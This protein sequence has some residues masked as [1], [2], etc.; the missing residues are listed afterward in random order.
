MNI[1]KSLFGDKIGKYFIICILVRLMIVYMVYLILN[2]K[3]KYNNNFLLKI[4]IIILFVI[5]FSFL[6]QYLTKIRDVGAFNQDVW[7]DYLRPIHGY[8]YVLSSYL[9]YKNDKKAIYLLLLDTII[10]ILGFINNRLN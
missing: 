8:L 9:I 5:G 1:L 7:W 4:S 2:N 6:L 3:I 10:G